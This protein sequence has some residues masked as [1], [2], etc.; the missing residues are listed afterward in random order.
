MIHLNSDIGVLDVKSSQVSINAG[1]GDP[2]MMESA[3]SLTV[4]DL[5]S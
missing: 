3:R 4:E 2:C 5:Y 1:R